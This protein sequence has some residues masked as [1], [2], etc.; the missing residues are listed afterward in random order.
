M[1]IEAS[2]Q[3]TTQA[4]TAPWTGALL[5]PEEIAALQQQASGAEPYPDDGAMN[6][7]TQEKLKFY[8][9]RCTLP[10][11]AHTR[12]TTKTWPLIPP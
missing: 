4:T 1:T 10:S 12:N 11:P 3:A 5:T 6:P 2:T 7:L 9:E 8:D